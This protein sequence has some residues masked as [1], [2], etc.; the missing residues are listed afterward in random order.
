MPLQTQTITLPFT[1]GVETKIDPKLVEGNLLELENAA[2]AEDG[3]PNRRAAFV[4]VEGSETE[5]TP[6]AIAT[7]GA[8][9]LTVTG[10]SLY[11]Y[12]PG[13]DRQTLRGTV[14]PCQLQK[15]SVRKT[16]QFARHPDVAVLGGLVCYVWVEATIAAGAVGLYASIVDSETGAAVFGPT[17][18]ASGTIASP[19]VVG[20]QALG[21]TTAPAFVVAYHLSPSKIVGIAIPTG[22]LV[23][24]TPV[25]LYTSSANPAALDMFAQD[26]SALLLH[27]VAAG[28]GATVSVQ[29]LLLAY[30]GGLL[31]VRAG[32]VTCLTQATVNSGEIAS[33]AIAPF[34]G[35]TVGVYALQEITTTYAIW[36]GTVT[37]T[38]STLS[39][40]VS[41]VSKYSTIA[42][43]S[44]VTPR[45]KITAACAG[46]LMRVFADM[47][48]STGATTPGDRTSVITLD[49]NS[50]NQTI[51]S[52]T[53]FVTSYSVP[54]GPSGPYI[55]GKP[56]VSDGE[57]YLPMYVGSMVTAD[58][59]LQSTWFLM[60]SDGVAVGRAMYG[61]YGCASTGAG[62]ATSVTVPSSPALTPS[63]F[64]CPAL[65]RGQLALADG[66][67]QNATPIGVSSLSVA[68][69]RGLST[70]Q[71]GA[72]QFFAGG[73]L[74]Q[75][76]GAEVTE[77]SFNLFPEGLASTEAAGSLTGTYQ[78]CALYEWVD[79]SGQRHQ[80]APS[81]P[82]TVTPSAEDVTITLPAL[83]VT[84][85][86]GVTVVLFRTLNN[87]TTFY[88]VNTIVEPISNTPTLTHSATVNY[89]DDTAD[90]VIEDNE[91]LYTTSGALENLGPTFCSAIAAHQGRLWMVGLETPSG[92]AFSQVAT[93][94]G[95]GFNEALS[96]SIPTALG[97]LSAIGILD[98]K[99]ILYT[100]TR[101]LALW[102]AGPSPDGLQGS[103]SE[104]QLL[105]S[106]VGC[107]EPRSIVNIPSGQMYQSQRGIYL[108]NRA[109]QDEYIGSSVEDY[110][111]GN[112][113][114]AAVVIESASQVRFVL[115]L[116]DGAA[117]A[118]VGAPG[119]DLGR[120]TLILNYDTQFQQWSTHATDE[121]ALFTGACVWEGLCTYADATVIA[122]DLSGALGVS[123]GAPGLRLGSDGMGGRL[124]QDSP[125]FL[126]YD[127]ATIPVTLTTQW[128]RLGNLSGFE[129]VKR[130]VLNG[131]FASDSIITIGVAINYDD[132]IVYTTT[133]PSSAAIATG[134]TIQL[135][136]HIQTQK[137]QAIRFT[138]TDTPVGDTGEGCDFAGM[139]LELG[140][141]KGPAKLP[142]AAS[143]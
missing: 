24:G 79:N 49:I 111:L 58:T 84:N 40:G 3:T 136:H 59:N 118:A 87:G 27:T 141:K 12:S 42:H 80:S 70:T 86:T 4:E 122:P 104:P 6:T 130:L 36:A 55:A 137:C 93:T 138:I 50:S 57:M 17:R 114:C 103:Y 11:A 7:Y 25:D 109:L 9:L 98:D 64:I 119:I 140:V 78:Y 14:S 52:P 75:Y 43:T 32:P 2:F 100:P 19:R 74:R 66:P 139:T 69:G 38:P 23:P 31:C 135:R 132:T 65:E 99:V 5:G 113:V 85:K 102:G 26:G 13:A 124:S 94:Q 48:A 45:S 128:I 20:L 1:K 62:G 117:G 33:V 121:D 88:R 29:A 16:S 106:D 22:T 61:S 82:L 8:E 95:L 76:D 44:V 108:L 134:S 131:D 126:D 97:G 96:G 127:S 125:G 91:I 18:I 73:A 101:K 112:T 10:K 34:P 68:F 110:V 115:Q 63:L 46:D 56:I 37:W 123:V 116:A 72:N 35:N 21:P 60:D 15:N 28:G 143:T 39:A 53:T 90:S 92:F 105:P 129:R 120:N 83:S 51:S 77:A 142:A 133:V 41:M 107:M 47:S 71:V 89:V 67:I 54:L 81:L 30:M